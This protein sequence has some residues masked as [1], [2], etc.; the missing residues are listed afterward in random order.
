M[1][2]R[3]AGWVGLVGVFVVALSLQAQECHDWDG[4]QASAG[5]SCAESIDCEDQS[6]TRRPGAEEICDG[7][8][9]DCDGTDDQGCDRW[10]DEPFFFPVL[11][12]LPF[13]SERPEP[14]WVCSTLTEHGFLA[15]SAT[16]GGQLDNLMT[17]R[18]YD[19]R[20]RQFDVARVIGDPDRTDPDDRG[21]TLVDAGSRVLAV[22]Y[23]M[24]G[25]GRGNV[26]TRLLDPLGRPLGPI[27]NVRATYPPAYGSAI[28]EDPAAA[29][30]G[31]EYGVFW[32]YG[33]E[34]LMT[35]LDRDGGVKEPGTRV[36]TTD[37][38]G[39]AHGLTVVQAVWDGANYVVVVNV[40]VTGL[41][42]LI[43]D[44]QGRIVAGPHSL[45]SG[46]AQNLVVTVAGDRTA[47]AW[48]E[49][50]LPA[51]S[52]RYL[53]Y[54]GSTGEKLFPGTIP[55][56][57]SNVQTAADLSID[58]SG[59][60]VSVVVATRYWVQSKN[61][62]ESEWWMWRVQPDGVVL[63]TQ[64][65][66]L[67]GDD[68]LDDNANVHWTGEE[69]AIVGTVET[70]RRLALARVVCSCQDEDQDG[71]D[72]CVELDCD[73]HNPFAYPGATEQ[74]RG[75]EDED[76]DGSY[77]CDDADCP[78]ASGPAD[79]TDLAWGDAVLEWSAVPGA[80]RYDLARGLVG[81]LQRRADFLVA[82][83]AGFELL[84]ASWSDDGR[85]PPAGDALWYLV[86]P[87]GTPC[88]LGSWAAE[89]AVVR[90]VRACD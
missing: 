67:S 51:G 12:A 27:V 83:C 66:L 53:A 20:G 45:E 8:D 48:A 30:N 74:C 6:W 82:E 43:V 76:C 54:L 35:A 62:Y 79:V 36:V 90:E 89:P 71:Q 55:L 75:L 49:Q 61:E 85:R 50:R 81:D 78:G 23:E 3:F 31:E 64:G 88:A 47:V 24:S 46:V 44:R 41:H 68:R 26:L 4:D 52:D 29:W 18:A 57:S 59:E 80:E 77:D 13:T 84:G 40:K 34:L 10:C 17:V 38:D 86:R 42:S 15:G 69:Y 60:L 1:K 70:P 87:E 63:D 11:Q 28:A 73:D 33:N 25:D 32:I 22:W 21:C 39:E 58:W 56:L 37:V 7:Y 19:R 2:V 72:A 5:I 65:R 16:R 9:T 14:I